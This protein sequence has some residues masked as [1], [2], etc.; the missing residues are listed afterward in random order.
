MLSEKA[1]RIN[2]KALCKAKRSNGQ[3]F[4]GVVEVENFQNFYENPNFL[5][6]MTKMID[7]TA[8]QLKQVLHV[9]RALIF[10]H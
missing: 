3:I 4:Y 9:I 8:S 6:A 1:I 10:C 7:S 5:S 2:E